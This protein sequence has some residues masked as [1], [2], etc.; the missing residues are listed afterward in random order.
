MNQRDEEELI[1]AINSISNALTEVRP[2]MN[3]NQIHQVKQDLISAISSIS[4]ALSE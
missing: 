2:E 4:K 1:R 3:E